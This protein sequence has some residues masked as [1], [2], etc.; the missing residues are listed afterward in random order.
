MPGAKDALA[1][2]ADWYQKGLIDPQFA[3]RTDTN[4]MAALF[5]GGQAGAVF[6]GWNFGY[7]VTDFP[8]NN[9]DAELVAVN[10]PLDDNG[11]FKV[12]GTGPSAAFVC[13]NK[14]F[15]HPE[16]VVK[17][18][19]CEFDMWREL[20]KEA[21]EM[22]KPT[23]DGGVD[24]GYMFPTGGFNL[25]HENCVPEAG[26]MARNW[27][28]EGKMECND[29]VYG[30]IPSVQGLAEYAKQYA[31][32]KDTGYPWV[33]YTCRYV[34]SDPALL[35]ADNI[36]FHDPVYSFVTE[37][38]ADLKP[39]LDT[40]EK[41]TYLKI[42]LGEQPIDAFDQFVEDWYAQGGQTM[43]DEVKAMIGE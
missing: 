36:E 42:V 23:K 17:V 5:S 26:V 27:V 21:A 39:N 24:W 19:N 6:A 18:I 29:P 2:L 12:Q 10:A 13:V 25:E 40:L 4:T 9:P 43:T 11:K 14:E 1:V 28:D 37:S 35:Y 41:T 3:T 7:Y 8:A 38:M 22:I 34:G 33:E 32:T 30:A 15:E 20:D 31:D 16:A